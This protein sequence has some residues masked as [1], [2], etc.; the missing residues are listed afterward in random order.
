MTFSPEI[1]WHRV[2]Q[3]NAVRHEKYASSLKHN[4]FFAS[5]LKHNIFLSL[6]NGPNIFVVQG[7]TIAWTCRQ[8]KTKSAQADPGEL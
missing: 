8:A 6:Q 1:S 3:R 2:R 7:Q 4:I 5:S